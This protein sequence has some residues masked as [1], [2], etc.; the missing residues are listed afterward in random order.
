MTNTSTNLLNELLNSASYQKAAQLTI[1]S[2]ELRQSLQAEVEWSAKHKWAGVGHALFVVLL[3]IIVGQLIVSG[4]AEINL[5][6]Y[7]SKLTYFFLL[8]MGYLLS[9]VG[10]CFVLFKSFKV[11]QKRKLSLLATHL[12]EKGLVFDKNIKLMTVDGLVNLE[13]NIAQAQQGDSDAL[14]QLSLALLEGRY[15][16]PNFKMA[17]ALAAI[18]ADLNNSRAA[19]LVA[20]AFDANLD[21]KL[22]AQEAELEKQADLHSHLYWLQKAA[23]LGSYKAK[24]ELA[25]KA[26]PSSL[27]AKSTDD[28]VQAAIG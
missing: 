14:L 5:Y 20:Q 16:K 13:N 22:A 19:Y 12:N 11:Y 21:V 24:S 27:E 23:A 25:R 6:Q 26:V 4:L 8:V 15:I 17:L 7:V 28:L 3:G 9:I 10:A 1:G 18:A 2:D